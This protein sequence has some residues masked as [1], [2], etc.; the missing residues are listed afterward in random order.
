MEGMARIN[1]YHMH[2]WEYHD[3]TFI[4]VQFMCASINVE[5]II[6]SIKISAWKRTWNR[7]LKGAI[8]LM[9]MLVSV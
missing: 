2:A 4:I 5:S 6:S 1:G 9:T 7:Y 3:E 8:S